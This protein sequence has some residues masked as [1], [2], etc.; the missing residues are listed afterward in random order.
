MKNYRVVAD[1]PSGEFPQDSEV[2]ICHNCLDMINRAQ[3]R[4]ELPTG[5]TLPKG[6]D[7]HFPGTAGKDCRGRPGIFK[8]FN[9]E[10][11][12][13]KGGNFG[14]GSSKENVIDFCDVDCVVVEAT[15][16]GMAHVDASSCA[17]D[18]ASRANRRSSLEA[19]QP[20]VGRLRN[21]ASLRSSSSMSSL[22]SSGAIS[23]ASALAVLCEVAGVDSGLGWGLGS[24]L[25]SGLMR[26]NGEVA[27]AFRLSGDPLKG[28]SN[29]FYSLLHRL[30]KL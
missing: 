6:T 19:M 22:Q 14:G 4:G 5:F 25:S 1:P 13:T 16:K 27:D 26:V 7:H 24:P 2:I 11:V 17:R 28:M 15:K 29:T 18:R 12:P 30:F 23:T 10:L 9:Q 21:S 20:V 8:T 3:R